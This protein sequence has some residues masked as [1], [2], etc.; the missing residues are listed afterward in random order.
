MDPRAYIV[1]KMPGKKAGI[2][3]AP[4]EGISYEMICSLL[5]ASAITGIEPGDELP[6]GCHGYADDNAL[7]DG[8]RGCPTIKRG[9]DRYPDFVCGPILFLGYDD[10]EDD[11]VPLTKKEAEACAKWLDAHEA[12]KEEYLRW[13]GAHPAYFG[14]L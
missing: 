14:A 13:A 9:T 6:H 4:K 1:I 11:S 2:K 8:W 3:P 10:E 7:S 12:S 5:G